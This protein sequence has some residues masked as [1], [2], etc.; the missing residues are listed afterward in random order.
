VV[1]VS[2][3]IENRN[4]N[5]N[6]LNRACLNFSPSVS[7]FR[8]NLPLNYYKGRNFGEKRYWWIRF[9]Q[10]RC[11]LAKFIFQDKIKISGKKFWLLHS[12]LS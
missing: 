5:I 10:I 3:K 6:M 9:G 4:P 11:N 7:S 12:F 2:Y 1:K 8:V